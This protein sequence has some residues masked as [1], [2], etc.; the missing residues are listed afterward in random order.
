[1]RQHDGVTP[2]FF[3]MPCHSAERR[4]FGF[5]LAVSYRT[6]FHFETRLVL[7]MGFELAILTLSQEAKK[8][9]RFFFETQLYS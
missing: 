7:K 9:P 3:R 5:F 8:A 1:M 6:I 2:V 4:I